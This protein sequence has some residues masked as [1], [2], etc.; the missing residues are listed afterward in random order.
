MRV[1]VSFAQARIQACLQHVR[2]SQQCKQELEC[3][4]PHRGPR[5]Q[6]LLCLRSGGVVRLLYLL[7]R[8]PKTEACE[9]QSGQTPSKSGEEERRASQYSKTKLPLFAG[10]SS[11]K[12][13]TRP[14]SGRFGIS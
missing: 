13:V 3:V 1:A 4:A 6:V 5:A 8:M 9:A 11:E 12:E 10:C 2:I 7:G 14:K